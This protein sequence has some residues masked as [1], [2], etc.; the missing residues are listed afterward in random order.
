MF[1]KLCGSPTNHLIID[2]ICYRHTYQDIV[3]YFTCSNYVILHPG[4][5]LLCTCF[6]SLLSKCQHIR[7]IDQ[8]FN[9]KKSMSKATSKMMNL[10]AVKHNTSTK[11]KPMIQFL[12]DD[13]LPIVK[14]HSSSNRCGDYKENHNECCFCLEHIENTT[15]VTKCQRCTFRVHESCWLHWLLENRTISDTSSACPLCS[16]DIQNKMRYESYF[17]SI[18]R[19]VN[20]VMYRR[21]C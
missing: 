7:F 11:D 4:E 14:P 21:S 8:C 17:D 3:F 13:I 15:K 16:T 18:T 10:G 19:S 20:I 9:Y 5:N 2:K 6:G 1:F 12:I